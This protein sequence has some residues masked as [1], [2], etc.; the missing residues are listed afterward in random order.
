M[1][2]RR[3]F[4]ATRFEVLRRLDTQHFWFTGR[5][6][7]LL[8]WLT[9]ARPARRGLVLDSGCGTGR[10]IAAVRALG[11]TTIGMDAAREFAPDA[12][13]SAWLQGDVTAIPCR[14]ACVDVVLMLDVLEHTDDLL[15]LKEAARVLRPS[16]LLLVT[17]PAY[18]WLW[19]V[20]DDR[21]GHLRR[22]TTAALAHV[23][24][25]A[26]FVPLRWQ[27]YQCLL[28]PLIVWARRSAHRDRTELEERPSRVLR[29]V[30]HVEVWLG[31]WIRWPVGST[32]V[33]MCSRR[34]DGPLPVHR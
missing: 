7:L 6:Q 11:F 28:F 12:T 24:G 30:T 20:R 9:R 3:S 31:R 17:V 14:D 25:E 4:H 10:N 19:S 21:A 18:P 27:R 34:V 16:G 13:S 5:R 1:P 2:P 8:D 33:V 15:A 32:L 23:L 29:W 26:G 22:Y